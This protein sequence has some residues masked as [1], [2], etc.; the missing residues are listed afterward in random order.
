MKLRFDLAKLW[1]SHPVLR[2]IAIWAIAFCLGVSLAFVSHELLF[3]EIAV[4][5]FHDIINLD[6]SN[7][8]SP[9]REELSSDYSQQDFERLLR[10]LVARDYWFLSTQEL[11]DYFLKEN[12]D[13]LPPQKAQQKKVL[14][15][16]D[17]GYQGAHDNILPVLEAIDRTT[18]KKV[19]VVWFVNSSFMGVTGTHLPHASCENF[20]DGVSKGYYDVQSHTAN[21]A[22]L[23]QLSQ[24]DLEK[25]LGRSQRELR[26][27]LQ[28]IQ[29]PETVA[30]HIAYPFG[31]INPKSLQVVQQFY[32][33]GYLY[34][35][36]PF[37]LSPFRQAYFI[38]RITVSR[39]D[40]V[41]RLLRIAAGGWL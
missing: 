23:T 15:T 14:I 7:E 28:D 41:R 26:Q 30:N 8:R 10:E 34:D 31:K 24:A 6:N 40:S 37:R 36:N 35:D 29:S 39:H 2:K 19:T 16:F 12:P 27:C 11:Y 32:Q 4:L 18:G 33:S 5:G 20:Q 9:F 3:E 22:D 21:H 13:P 38:P 17:D 1:R 25:E